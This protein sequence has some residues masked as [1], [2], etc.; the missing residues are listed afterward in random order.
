MV[1]P[2]TYQFGRLLE[3]ETTLSGWSG[4]AWIVSL[5]PHSHT[6]WPGMCWALRVTCLL[7]HQVRV[8]HSRTH[9]GPDPMPQSLFMQ[10]TTV[11]LSVAMSTTP[12]VWAEVLERAKKTGFKFQVL[13][14]QFASGRHQ[15]PLAIRYPN[16][17]PQS[18]IGASVRS[19]EHGWVSGVA[20]L[21]DICLLEP[22]F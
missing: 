1:T 7:E 11:V 15:V 6:T 13:Y 10:A 16:W 9:N 21:E 2:G 14:M 5:L 19:E 17:M 3:G 12:S 22:A 20:D 18:S 8:L 4:L